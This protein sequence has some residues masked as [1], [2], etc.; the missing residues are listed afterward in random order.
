MLNWPAAATSF[1]TSESSIARQHGW[2]RRLPGYDAN[3][4]LRK[5]FL[6]RWLFSFLFSSF[7]AMASQPVM[8]EIIGITELKSF[9]FSVSLDRRSKSSH[10]KSKR[11]SME[12]PGEEALVEPEPHH[13]ILP[14]S[15]R[16]KFVNR[17]EG[18]PRTM[19]PHCQYEGSGWQKFPKV[20]SCGMASAIA[21][22]FVCMCCLPFCCDCS[23][24]W[25]WMCPCCHQCH[26][27]G[28]DEIQP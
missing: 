20:S 25:L 11:T 12:L 3:S 10:W 19:C 18:T 2:R 27:P 7:G 22:V 14:M 28:P 5:C 21:L 13:E 6:F 4:V 15:K 16:S 17:S 8:R 23:I 24:E 9:E 26:R 1:R